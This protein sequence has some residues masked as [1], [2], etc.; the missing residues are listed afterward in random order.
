MQSRSP[1]KQQAGTSQADT[2][3]VEGSAAELQERIAALTERVNLLENLLDHTPIIVA[4]KDQEGRFTYCNRAFCQY[5]GAEPNELI[6]TNEFY[7]A[8]PEIAESLVEWE[9][10]IIRTGIPATRE[11]FAMRQDGSKPIRTQTHKFPMN[12]E[13]MG[14]S[15]LG[16]MVTDVS[17]LKDAQLS[18][19]ESE[20]KYRTL[21]E[22]TGTGFLIATEEG[23]VVDANEKFAKMLGYNT[24]AEVIGSNTREWVLPDDLAKRDGV[25][26]EAFGGRHGHLVAQYFHKDGHAI[27]VE[28]HGCSL[29][30]SGERFIFGL[31]RDISDRVK[32]RQDLERYRQQL[33]QLV[34]ERTRE[35]RMVNEELQAFSYSVSHDLRAPLRSIAGFS[36]ILLEDY[37]DLLDEPGRDY[38]DRII[39]GSQ[40]MEQL[41][42]QMLAMSATSTHQLDLKQIDLSEMV[43]ELLTEVAQAHEISKIE[44]EI[45][46]GLTAAG[47][48]I[49]LRTALANMVSNAVKFSSAKSNVRIKF[50][51]LDS[52]TDPRQPFYI[53]DNGQ[54]FDPEY[55][56]KIFQPFQRLHGSEVVE[57]SGIGLT[58]V[59]RIVNRHGGEV[60]AKSEPGN[61]ATFYFT[62]GG[63]GNGP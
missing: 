9:E 19:R 17:D 56:D 59:A 31:V 26:A 6:G 48:A 51:R 62:L 60:W 33:E 41:I 43:A 34:D 29:I 1:I 22:N 40:R 35:L 63:K 25:V 37:R 32:A 47:D 16:I 4:A 15:V 49:L 36:Q 2:D 44:V 30:Q 12:G 42:E 45:E 39:A 20:L 18:L 50:G 61:G 27:T 21:V 14:G 38:F 46:P 3:A 11:E 24:P 58:N 23:T 5:V 13:Q 57:G 53:Q 28:V 10:D 55:V 8:P 52:E 7:F 54:G